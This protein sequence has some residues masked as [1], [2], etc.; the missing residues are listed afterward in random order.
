METTAPND[1]YGLSFGLIAG[2][3]VCIITLAQYLGG[4]NAYLS[5]L[6]YLTYAAITILAILAGLRKKKAN[7][8]Y[9]EFGE[10]LKTTFTVFAL[11]LLLQTIFTYILL[12]FID[13]SFKEALTQEVMT[14]SEEMM[15]R[16]GATDE[17]IDKA[18]ENERGKDPFALNRVML[19][20]AISCILAFIICLIIS[21]SIKKNKP[22]FNNI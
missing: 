21:V 2:L 5:P 4:L 20:Y 15:R 16:F 13:V 19:G 9:L 12:N 3:I 8:G 1:N 17:Q 10:A 22:V 7:E 6:G 18:M 11:A 14:K